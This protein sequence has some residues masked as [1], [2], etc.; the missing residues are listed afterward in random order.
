MNQNWK[1]LPITGSIVLFTLACATLM[2]TNAPTPLP[3]ATQEPSPAP[4]PTPTENPPTAAVEEESEITLEKGSD[5]TTLFTDHVG[6]YQIVF[7]E[8]WIA[9]NLSEGDMDLAF[10]AFKESNPEISPGMLD[11]SMQLLT[12]NTRFMALDTNTG[13]YSGEH[14]TAAYSILD[15]QTGNFP[16]GF[17][18]DATAQALPQQLP[19]V[20][21]VSSGVT[22]NSNGVEFGVIEIKLFMKDAAGNA[23]TIYEKMLLFQ[24]NDLTIMAIL[25]THETLRDVVMGHFDRI[26]ES[27]SLLP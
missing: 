14:M 16:L 12:E 8:N 25:V 1:I 17:L 26:Q 19:D 7:P 24:N 3:A 4:N 11:M 13:H 22:T 9:L 2:P 5:G 15:E 23:Q 27:I 20:E 21:I 10:D 6:G 18:V